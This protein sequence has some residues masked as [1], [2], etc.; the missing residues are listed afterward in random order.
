MEV[1]HAV[2]PL[3]QHALDTY[4][5]ETAKLES[6]WRCFGD[7]DLTFRPDSKSRTLEEILK[8]QLLSERRF[9]AEFLGV[10]ERPATEVLPPEGTVN[11]YIDRLKTA[12][13]PRLT[14]LA[15]QV[16]PWWLKE[17]QFFATARQ[18]IWILLRRILHTA[19]HRTQLTTYLRQL[20]RPVPATYGPSADQT[21]STADPTNSIDAASR[22]SI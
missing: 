21:W 11:S 2:E 6:V 22:K 8:H 1:P 3:L 10:P 5:S 17:V 13:P 14:F 16:A 12:V 20:D 9:F 4:A 18:R 15:L 19:H 7:A